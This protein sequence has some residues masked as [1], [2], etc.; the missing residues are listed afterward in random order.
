MKTADWTVHVL[1]LL[2]IIFKISFFFI[3]TKSI[4]CNEMLQHNLRFNVKLCMDGTILN[5]N[6]C[7]FLK[8]KIFVKTR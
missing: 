1:Q 4:I 8:T 2:D 5:T 3:K 7:F 6:S